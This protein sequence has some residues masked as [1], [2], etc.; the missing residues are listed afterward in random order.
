MPDDIP[1]PAVMPDF[2]DAAGLEA[3]SA[4]GRSTPMTRSHGD[5][6]K[7]APSP[8]VSSIPWP[9]PPAPEQFK[10]LVS[11]ADS[12]GAGLA[13]MFGADGV[14]PFST[15][16]T[17]KVA[18]G[19]WPLAYY[20]GAGGDKPTKGILFMYAAL[21][22]GGLVIMHFAQIKAAKDKQKASDA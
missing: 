7:G 9:P 3:L 20:Y 19:V 4:G 17:D 21:S 5:A 15:E 2:A 11:Q 8:A 12:M 22:I 14:T 6:E 13:S 1:Q 18:D 10:A 16:I